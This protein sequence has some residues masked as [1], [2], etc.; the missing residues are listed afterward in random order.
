MASRDASH[1]TGCRKRI[2]VPGRLIEEKQRRIGQQR[3]REGEAGPHPRGVPEDRSVGGIGETDLVEEPLG[4]GRGLVSGH[5][6]QRGEEG[7]VSPPADPPV[8]RSLIADHDAQGAPSGHCVADHVVAADRSAPRVR[9]HGRAEDPD[10][11][12][13]PGTVRAEQRHHLAGLDVE[14]DAVER[15]DIAEALADLANPDPVHGVDATRAMPSSR[16]AVLN[17]PDS[18]NVRMLTIVPRSEYVEGGRPPGKIARRLQR[19][20]LDA[21]LRD[22]PGSAPRR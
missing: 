18:A 9:E 7:E 17:P 6:G 14:A 13:L 8:V 10:Q 16:A 21:P 1:E 3:A 20:V 4:A 19:L 15:L 5:A 2:E 11:G 22:A 12:A